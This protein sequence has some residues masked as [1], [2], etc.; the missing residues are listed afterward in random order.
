MRNPDWLRLFP[1]SDFRW[2]MNLRP[3]D[4]VDFFS[5]SEESA[6][7]LE[8][9][10]RLLRDAPGFHEVLPESEKEIIDQALD[11]LSAWTG[12]TF[13]DGREAGCRLEPDW[14][15]L[16]EQVDGMPRVVAGSVCFP[17]GWSLPE[18]AGLPLDEVHG[19]VPRLNEALGRQIATFLGKLVP[20]TPWERENWGLSA[21]AAR[22]HH[23]RHR[24]R[25]LDGGE[26]LDEAWIRLERQILV[27][28]S[29]DGILFGIHVGNHRLDEVAGLSAVL[30][31]R[32]ARALISMPEDAAEYKGLL[33]A[34]SGI[35]A[36]L[37]AGV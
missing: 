35:A 26:T 24:R 33:A 20:G 6:V 29:G 16:R 3:G 5:P 15:L 13:E 21:D 17:S 22:D 37:E 7:V 9:R 2:A 10:S 8:E 18:K 31:A 36:R 32:M 30:P 25:R 1:D 11:R 28:L 4:A 14:V 23:P 27:R 19:N 34:R 12:Q